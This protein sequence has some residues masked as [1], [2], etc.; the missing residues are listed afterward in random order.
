MLPLVEPRSLTNGS[1][2]F[3]RV[4]LSST[5]GI[6]EGNAFGYLMNLRRSISL[7]LP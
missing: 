1:I 2:F 7:F 5:D 6:A 4:P 3:G